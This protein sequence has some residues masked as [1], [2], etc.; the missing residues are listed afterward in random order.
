M[1]KNLPA[2]AGDPGSVPGWRI[3]PGEGNCNPLQYSCLE[4][5]HR[6]RSLA[7][8]SPWD[9]KT[10]RLNNKMEGHT[11]FKGTGL[12]VKAVLSPHVPL[13]RIQ[14]H[15]HFTER[16]TGKCSPVGQPGEQNFIMKEIFFKREFW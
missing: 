4:K 7:G 13:A 2:N 10:E 9:H 3:S 8:Y 16:E 6:Q 5:S 14:P 12:E 15:D 11:S 1:V